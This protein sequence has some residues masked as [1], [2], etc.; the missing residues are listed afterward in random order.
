[1]IDLMESEVGEVTEAT[2]KFSLVNGNGKF[3]EKGTKY[4]YLICKIVN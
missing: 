2:R 3:L 4:K 1:M